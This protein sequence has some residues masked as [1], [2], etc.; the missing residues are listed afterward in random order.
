MHVVQKSCLRLAV[1]NTLEDTL[2]VSMPLGVSQAHWLGEF[3][4]LEVEE[5]PEGDQLLHLSTNLP[6]KLVLHWGVEGGQSSSKAGWVLPPDSCR[7]EGTVAYKKR[8][9]QTPWKCVNFLHGFLEHIHAVFPVDLHAN[10][11]ECH[12]ARLAGINDSGSCSEASFVAV[13][14]A[15]VEG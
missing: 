6:G 10:V 4:Q 13:N 9:L 15:G 3:M 1:K 14:F 7:P 8:A 11:T 2:R 5:S 12:I